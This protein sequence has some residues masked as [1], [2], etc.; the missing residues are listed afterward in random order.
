MIC[1]SAAIHQRE[2]DIDSLRRFFDSTKVFYYDSIDDQVRSG[3][4]VEELEKRIRDQEW[5]LREVNSFPNTHVRYGSITGGD[6]RKR[7][8]KEVDI[9]I[10]VDMMNHAIPQNMDR[11][12]LLA[13]DR[14]FTPLAETL[15]QMGLTVEVAGDFR[16]TSDV[17]REVADSYRPLGITSY[18]S[19]VR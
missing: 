18:V 5:Y 16:S 17:L 9:L 2:L 13:G 15:V 12:V 4:Q 10:A 8:Q 3:E 6:R 7:R 19:L 14:D 1:S 11:A